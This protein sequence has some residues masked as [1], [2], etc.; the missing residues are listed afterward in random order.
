MFSTS[1]CAYCKPVKKII[2]ELKPQYS[3]R[4]TFTELEVDTDAGA[5]RLAKEHVVNAVP[6]ILVIAKQEEKERLIGDIDTD[7]IINVLERNL[8]PDLLSEES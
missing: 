3:D 4:V 6:T 5:M 1:Q 7:K 2:E 8:Q